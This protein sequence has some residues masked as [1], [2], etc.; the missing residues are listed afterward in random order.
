M[1]LGYSQFSPINSHIH[2]H[3]IFSILHTF[4]PKKWENEFDNWFGQNAGNHEGEFYKSGWSTED[5]RS[6]LNSGDWF[7]VHI[8][9]LP[10][11]FIGYPDQ[12]YWP[13]SPPDS[14]GFGRFSTP[15]SNSGAAQFAT[16]V[17]ESMNLLVSF[18]SVFNV[19]IPSLKKREGKAK[20]KA[21]SNLR[22]REDHA[23]RIYPE[24]TKTLAVVWSGV[25]QDSSIGN[26][27]TLRRFWERITEVYNQRRPGRTIS[28][29][30]K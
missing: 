16:Q 6:E 27:Q 9:T 26:N 23:H 8:P 21:K 25:S 1:E 30:E 17:L 24:E 29:D 13:Y 19:P 10:A 7:S 14:Q 5:S 12:G 22:H 28:R 4:I 11:L 18:E 20:A 2:S 3:N 15:L